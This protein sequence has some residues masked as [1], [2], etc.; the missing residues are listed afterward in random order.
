M[1]WFKTLLLLG[2]LGMTWVE[3]DRRPAAR[4]HTWPEAAFE[5]S[6]TNAVR[7]PS[8]PASDPL[9]EAARPAPASRGIS[10]VRLP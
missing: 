6:T 4:T 5:A 2:V 7:T 10:V 1:S 9:D 3:C 8:R